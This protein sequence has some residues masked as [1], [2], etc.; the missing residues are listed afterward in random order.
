M[1]IDSVHSSVKYTLVSINSVGL[2]VL[3]T[4]VYTDT[5]K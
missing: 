4:T 2:V 3:Q 5:Y 1:C